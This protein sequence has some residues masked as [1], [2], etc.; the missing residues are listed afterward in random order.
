MFLVFQ[1]DLH[2]VLGRHLLELVRDPQLCVARPANGQ[3]GAR[4]PAALADLSTSGDFRAK[5][6]D[7]EKIEMKRRK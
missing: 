5:P 7:V 3:S 1:H 4:C 6:C 2:L